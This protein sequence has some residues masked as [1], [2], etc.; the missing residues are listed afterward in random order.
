MQKRR[1]LAMVLAIFAIVMAAKP[2]LAQQNTAEKSEAA[3]PAGSYRLDFT[4]SEMDDSKTLNSRAYTM[5]LTGA[6]TG[7]VRAGSRMP[8]QS[9]GSET[10]PVTMSYLEIGQSIDCRI[11]AEQDRYLVLDTAVDIS[12]MAPAPTGG[13]VPLSSK[14]PII[15]SLKAHTFGSVEVGKPTVI[16]S[17]DDVSSKRRFR[18]EVVVTKIR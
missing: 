6:R 10:G 1:T 12:S 5:M 7:Q 11:E 9:A 8:V 13:E 15:R 17:L 18:L 14:N 4:V 2:S 3:K 16:S